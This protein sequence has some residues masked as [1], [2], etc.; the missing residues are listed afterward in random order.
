MENKTLLVTG[1][2]GFIG[3]N[4]INYLLTNKPN[5]KI[6]N[7]DK[8]TYAA[9]KGT[10]A[11]CDHFVENDLNEAYH[12]KGYKEKLKGTK[13]DYCVNFA[14]ESHVDNSNVDGSPFVNSNI[15]G[16]YNLVEFL[17]KE[18]RELERFIHISTDE[19]YGPAIDSFKE[20]HKLNPTS[21]YAASK[22][23]AEH[24]V[25]SA[26]KVFSFPAII[27]RCCN[28][29]GPYQHL[30]KFIPKFIT[31][32]LGGY[33]FPLYDGG[34]QDREWIF[35]EKKAEILCKLLTMPLDSF[36]RGDILNI[37][38]VELNNKEMMRII[39]DIMK[40]LNVRCEPHIVPSSRA[41]HDKCYRVDD[42]KLEKLLGSS[43]SYHSLSCLK[44]DL[45]ETI[46][47]YINEL[48]PR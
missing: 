25:L 35:A 24:L 26:T 29:F 39:Q 12:F 2:C 42:Y 3:T 38:G 48:S 23:A 28:N 4:F 32:C 36:K 21:Y 13:I 19:V 46:K 5:W 37:S 47:Y 20:E 18:H 17:R 45:E 9:N 43:S 6:V 22:A 1:G 10:P 31:A 33:N 34:S 7:I 14:A 44:T 11:L 16:T 40:S 27:T 15:A 30:E 41:A 8:M